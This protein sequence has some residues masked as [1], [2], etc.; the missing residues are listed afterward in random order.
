MPVLVRIPTPLRALTGGRGALP[1]EA[2]TVAEAIARLDAEYPGLGERLC[3]AD[4]SIR[5]FLNVYKNDEDIRFLQGPGTPLQSGD[6]LNIVPAMA[7][8]TG[9]RPVPVPGERSS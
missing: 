6:E 7:G 5:R 8:G 3:E 2:A 4:G 1:V 9:R